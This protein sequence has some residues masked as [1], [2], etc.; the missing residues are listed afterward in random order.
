MSIPPPPK[1]KQQKALDLAPPK[2][3][4]KKPEGNYT[5]LSF[6]VSPEFHRQFKMYAAAQGEKMVEIMI[7]AV[8]KEMEGE[9]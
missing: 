4:T 8:T 7:R 9:G 2:P 6:K 3:L 5:P 1:K